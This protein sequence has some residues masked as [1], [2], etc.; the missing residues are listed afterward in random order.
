MKQSKQ[1]KTVGAPSVEQATYS[2]S[3]WAAH[4]QNTTE[5]LDCDG[6]FEKLAATFFGELGGTRTVSEIFATVAG[7]FVMLVFC[8][9]RTKLGD[10]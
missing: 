5:D 6:E 10:V 3:F 8:Q 1:R 2:R 4:S 9:S 7:R